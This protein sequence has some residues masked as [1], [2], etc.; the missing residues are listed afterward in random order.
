M[1]LAARFLKNAAAGTGLKTAEKNTDR[2]EK[3]G[4]KDPG[5]RRNQRRESTG[6]KT[7]E[8]KIEEKGTGLKT[9]HYGCQ[10][11]GEVERCIQSMVCEPVN[12]NWFGCEHNPLRTGFHQM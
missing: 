4:S 10:G 6:L 11:V 5:G 9:R 1:G 3:I 2:R 7:A 12:G 8:E